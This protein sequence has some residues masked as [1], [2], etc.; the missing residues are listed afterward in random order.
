MSG[1]DQQQQELFQDFKD[2]RANIE[3]PIVRKY[4]QQ[5][6]D[7]RDE[8][9]AARAE[10]KNLRT[11][12]QA[13]HRNLDADY[14]V[15]P[16]QGIYDSSSGNEE[17]SLYEASPSMDCDSA[18]W[19]P[20]E[21][22]LRCYATTIAYSQYS[23]LCGTSDPTLIHRL[24]EH[25]LQKEP[26][27]ILCPK[28]MVEVPPGGHNVAYLHQQIVEGAS[29]FAARMIEARR[30]V[31]PE[32]TTDDQVRRLG[33]ANI[34]GDSLPV[35]WIVTFSRPGIVDWEEG[36]SLARAYR[37]VFEDFG[38]DDVHCLVFESDPSLLGD[39]GQKAYFMQ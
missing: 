13:A 3:A 8:L 18:P 5:I 19:A 34:A 16:S 25:E 33:P 2:F 26:S 1:D 6:D 21:D 37:R 32:V 31:H 7:L 17:D 22:T 27:S 28:K 39:D 24:F 38:A 9:A 30:R 14:E 20:S 36:C 15:S 12:S 23:M 29:L 10:I 4:Q 11:G 35:Y